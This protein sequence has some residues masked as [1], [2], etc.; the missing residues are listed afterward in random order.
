MSLLGFGEGRD[1]ELYAPGNSTAAP[2]GG[3]GVILRIVEP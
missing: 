3:T 2:A 1:G